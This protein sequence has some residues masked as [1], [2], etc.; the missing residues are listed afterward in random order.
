M[1]QG[2]QEALGT[3]RGQETCFP[4]ASGGNA[5]RVRL[6][7]S[8]SKLG[9]FCVVAGTS[10]TITAQLL[11]RPNPAFLPSIPV[12]GASLTAPCMFMSSAPQ[13]A[14]PTSLC[15]RESE[16]QG[17]TPEQVHPSPLPAAAAGGHR[18]A[19]SQ[20]DGSCSHLH[21]WWPGVVCPCKEM[22]C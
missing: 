11:P 2:K 16:V 4:R 12:L 13:G 7:D 10:C 8:E 14:P 5:A 15:P 20:G 1:D 6:L 17:R 18:Q 22:Q 3:G 21:L 19:L 9:L